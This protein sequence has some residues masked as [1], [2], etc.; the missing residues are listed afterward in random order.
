MRPLYCVLAALVFTVA[1]TRSASAAIVVEIDRAVQRMAVSVDG[2]PRYNWRV[3]TARRG[4]ITPPG[5]YHPEMLAR[6]WFSRKYYNSPMP[7]SIFFYGGFA[8]HGSYEISH[9][10]RPASH[11]CVRLDPGNAAILFGL[12]QHEGMTATTI[13]I[14]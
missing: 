5:T 12:V 11:G 3:S 10:G 6:R 1:L 13:V 14:H 9:L 2:A 8:I 4:Y 7:H